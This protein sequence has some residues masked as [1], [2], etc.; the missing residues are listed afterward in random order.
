MAITTRAQLET[1]IADWRDVPSAQ[2][3]ML[4]DLV[5]IAEKRIFREARTI[6][7]EAALSDVI[8]A[9]GIPTPS[10]YI[11]LKIAYVDGSPIRKL[12]RRSLDWLY[13]NYPQRSADAKPA[14]IA[15][16][17]SNFIFGPYP[18]SAYTIKGTYYKDLTALATSAVN[19][20]FT[21]SPDLYLFACLAESEIILGSDERISLWEAKYQKILSDV[22]GMDDAEDNSGG[23]LQI[24]PD[25]TSRMRWGS[26]P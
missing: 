5:M 20:L 16:E 22:N 14:F 11:A 6:Y 13:A 3:T 23:V 10:S 26:I 24:R 7:Q 1:A 25:I 18:D 2:L 4:D 15:R 12:E 9:G 17:A 8:T 19:P 21:A